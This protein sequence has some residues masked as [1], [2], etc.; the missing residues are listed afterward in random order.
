MSQASG[1]G[2]L[3]TETKVGH[4]GTDFPTIIGQVDQMKGDVCWSDV[5]R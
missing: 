5:V 4:K 3:L 1:L 2:F